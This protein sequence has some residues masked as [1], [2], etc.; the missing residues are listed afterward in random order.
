MNDPVTL[1]ILGLA[2]AIAVGVLL[3][4]GR[5]LATPA[6]RTRWSDR[7]LLDHLEETARDEAGR[8]L[9][10]ELVR[11]QAEALA[12]RYGA[13]PAAPTSSPN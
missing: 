13:R 4:P 3:I 1:G 10:T 12:G 11:T 8:V 5:K 9:R 2:A 6:R 7:E